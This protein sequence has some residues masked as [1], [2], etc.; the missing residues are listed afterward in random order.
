MFEKVTWG[1]EGKESR[2]RRIETDGKK[3]E[4]M[5]SMIKSMQDMKEMYTTK[6]DV[7]MLAKAITFVDNLVLE[8]VL[9]LKLMKKGRE[10]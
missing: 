4:H 1:G 5:A 8:K 9:Q 10:L 7:S 2:K 3:L 6:L